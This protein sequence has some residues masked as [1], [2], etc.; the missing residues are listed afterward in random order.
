[1]AFTLLGIIELGKGSDRKSLP[2]STFRLHLGGSA[3]VEDAFPDGFRTPRELVLTNN[4][5]VTVHLALYPSAGLIYERE[6]HIS[7]AKDCKGSDVLHL[8]E[9]TRFLETPCGKTFVYMLGKFL[10]QKIPGLAEL[11]AR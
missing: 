8:K 5:A 11:I 7:K 1:M 4:T 9:G 10:G 2:D 3:H 6:L